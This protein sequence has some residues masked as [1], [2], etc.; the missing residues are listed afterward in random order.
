MT[1]SAEEN[2]LLRNSDLE[3]LQL[4]LDEYMNGYNNTRT[5]QGKRCQG[6]TPMET[7]LQGRKCYDAKNLEN[8]AA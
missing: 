8:L 6:R 1:I 3:T 7:F 5:H 4:D 2:P